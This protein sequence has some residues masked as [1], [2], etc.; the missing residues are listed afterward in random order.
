MHNKEVTMEKKTQEIN[1][2]F[3][4]KRDCFLSKQSQVT[5][6]IYKAKI[7]STLRKY[8]EK[9]YYGASQ[10]TF[11]QHCENHKKS[12]NHKKHRTDPELSKEYWRLKKTRTTTTISY[13][14][15]MP[16]NKKKNCLLKTF[17]H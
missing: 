13:F 3:I 5:D 14:K 17:H 15:K 7:I 10:G 12:F 4:N 1:R 6:V 9:I 16:T 2:N 11:K 8:N